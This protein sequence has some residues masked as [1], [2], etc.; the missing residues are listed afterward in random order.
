MRNYVEQ[1]THSQ[2]SVAFCFE[3]EG[4]TPIGSRRFSLVLLSEG[5]RLFTSEYIARKGLSSST[6]ENYSD[7]VLSF[8]KAIGNLPVHD[9]TPEHILKWRTWMERRLK[10]GTI[11]G[12]M[13]KLKNILQ[14]CNRKGLSNFDI[15][16]LYLPKVPIGLP[17]FLYDYEIEALI[18]AATSDRD[19]AIISLLFTSGIRAGELVRLTKS[20]LDGRT[21]YIR[22]AKGSKSRPVY[23]SPRTNEYLQ[24]YLRTRIDSSDILFRNYQKKAFEVGSI[25]KLLQKIALDAGITKPVHAHVLRHST[26]TH[27][28]RNGVDT[29]HVQKLLG[30]AYISTTQVYVHLL[31]QDVQEAHARVFN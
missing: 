20:D 26:A 30:H 6:A 1:Q 21:L 3:S 13:S 9:I 25:T 5:L 28:V 23:M 12:Y 7:A 27:M 11:R 17:K 19:K 10:P 2:W 15:D 8:T 14:F 22:L 31:N 4:L 29:S 18:Q 16:E 24:S